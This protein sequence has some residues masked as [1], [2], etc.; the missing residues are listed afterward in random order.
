MNVYFTYKNKSKS[1]TCIL[2]ANFFFFCK[3]NENFFGIRI[4]A[5]LTCRI[6][7]SICIRRRRRSLNRKP[8]K[9]KEFLY[10]TTD[11][12]SLFATGIMHRKSSFLIA[13]TEVVI[14]C[15]HVVIIS[16]LKLE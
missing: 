6:I 8:E 9:S 16:R 5:R 1:V 15:T 12:M 11:L 4:F 14:P 10:S 2:H 3:L 7:I 13:I